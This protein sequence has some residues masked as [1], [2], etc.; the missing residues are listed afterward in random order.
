MYKRYIETRS[1]N[2]CSR[3][4]AISITYYECV[5]VALVT[6]HAKCLRRVI[7]LTVACL[8]VPYFSTLSHKRQDFQEKVIQH[9]MC[10]SIFS[11]NLYETFLIL[12]R[13]QR[14][15]IIDVHWS[16]CKVPDI[17]TKIRA[18]RVQTQLDSV[19]YIELHVSTYLRSSSGSQVVIKT[20]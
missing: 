1:R 9:K 3:G 19:Y 18:V 13:I 5:S 17:S 8:A 10:V 7:F 11:T 15:I 6:Q 12:R 16:S 14:D 20:H 4:K 2:H